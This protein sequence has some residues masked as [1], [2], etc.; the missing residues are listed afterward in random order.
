MD[1]IP[2]DAFLWTAVALTVAAIA[3]RS[4]LLYK[5]THSAL[6]GKFAVMSLIMTV[7][8]MFMGIPLF[9]TDDTQTLS[10]TFAIGGAFYMGYFLYQVYLYWWLQLKQRLPLYLYGAPFL[11]AWAIGVYALIDGAGKGSLVSIEGSDVTLQALHPAVALLSMVSILL[12]IS[13]LR[14]GRENARNGHPA[15]MSY[16]FA[17]VFILLGIYQTAATLVHLES[18]EN[19]RTFV[20]I[21]VSFFW[22]VFFLVKYFSKK[23]A[24]A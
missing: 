4:F 9:F 11:A 23:H 18:L 24:Q 7:S 6:A 15:G 8:M 5:R 12:G 3:L 16:V 20:L 17:V 19:V 1:P 13:L 22:V 10:V 2:K 21:Y 14:A